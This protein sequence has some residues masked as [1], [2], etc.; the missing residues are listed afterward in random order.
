M[1]DHTQLFM[2]QQRFLLSVLIFGKWQL[3]LQ[4]CLKL[5]IIH[6]LFYWIKFS[7]RNPA[8]TELL[9]VQNVRGNAK[10]KIARDYLYILVSLAEITY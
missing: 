4:D 5:N 7:P 2:R 9:H 10:K 1:R 6:F 8:S 3:R